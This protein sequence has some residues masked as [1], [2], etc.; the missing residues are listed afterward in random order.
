MGNVETRA[1]LVPLAA[2]T[3]RHSF[4]LM[5]DTNADPPVYLPGVSLELVEWPRTLVMSELFDS[6][7]ALDALPDGSNLELSR[8]PGNRAPGNYQMGEP[9]MRFDNC[10]KL[11]QFARFDGGIL[12]LGVV[13]DCTVTIL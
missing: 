12:E 13:F 7:L 11:R 3:D 6:A 5:G 1:M 2:K 4:F 8:I 9:L 10:V